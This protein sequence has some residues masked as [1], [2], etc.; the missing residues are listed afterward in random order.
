MILAAIGNINGRDRAL[1]AALEAIAGEGIHTIVHTGNAIVG[2]PGGNEVVSLLEQYNVVC[3]QGNND[4]LA[5]RYSRK[6]E[7]LERKLDPALVDAIREANDR[8]SSQNLE[9]VRDWRKSRAFTLED[10]AVFACHGSPGNP[11]EILTPDTPLVKWRR[12]RE[13]ARADI[14]LCGGAE[15]LFS[16][17]V[18]GSLFVC[19]G[20]LEG[21][22][23][24]VS[25]TCINTEGTPWEAAPVIVAP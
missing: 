2:G 13:M 25:Y 5:V 3:V 20:A 9:K 10:L 4:R 12:Q 11:R 1:A 8:L 7:S 19:P 16:L 17:E 23:G 24:G 22:S 6:Q 14:I 21:A 18:D 15:S